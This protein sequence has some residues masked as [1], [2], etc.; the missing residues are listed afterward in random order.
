MAVAYEQVRDWVLALPG[1]AEVMVEEW[2]TRP[3]GWGTK[4][5]PP[6]CRAATPCR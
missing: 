2:G 4:C 5:S 6:A 1:C 3:C